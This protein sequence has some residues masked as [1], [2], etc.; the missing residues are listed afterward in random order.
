M[1]HM[2][3]I[4]GPFFGIGIGTTPVRRLFLL[5]T[6]RHRFMKNTY[7]IIVDIN[8]KGDVT[9][10]QQALDNA[11]NDDSAYYIYI[12]PGIYREKLH[13]TR[14]NTHLIGHSSIGTIIANTSANGLLT[15]DG[16]IWGTYNSYT[17]NI[18]THNVTTQSLTIE[19]TF[20]FLANQKKD[21]DD[22]SKITA[23][24]A[25]ALL[26]G[27]DASYFQCKDCVLKSYQDTLFV[28]TGLSYFEST[29]IWGTVDF[30][31]GG[32]T[33]V[34][35][36]CHLVSRWRD[37]VKEDSPWG[38]ISAPSTHIEQPFGLVFLHCK[39][40]KENN[41]V[42]ANSYKLGRPWHPTTQFEN[43][44]YADP[45]A[46]GHCAYIECDIGNHI[47]GWDKMH[48]KD[49]DG[50]TQ[51]F[52]A[53]ESRFHTYENQ[54]GE[55]STTIDPR[56]EISAEKRKHYNLHNILQGWTPSLII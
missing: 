44:S 40:I 32:G 52:Y 39:L 18:D 24:Q 46:I 17:I 2:A 11:P 20:D 8:G 49:K 12:R 55:S 42:A 53:E 33:A 28:S 22:E 15:K 5:K 4:S 45:Q 26:I 16:K 29:E 21:S 43:G 7:N 31:F 14:P 3:Q 9:T 30:I 19:N 13:I 48:G 34:F 47:D 37:D 50:N 41:E 6:L 27:K 38:Y 36:H 23:T 54:C 56:Y 51:W 10:I 1:F 25:V 35:N